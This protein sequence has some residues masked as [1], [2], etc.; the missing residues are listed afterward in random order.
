MKLE[1]QKHIE[2]PPSVVWSITEDVERWPE[3]T[4]TVSRITRLDTGPFDVGSTARIKQPG[5]PETEWR[6]TALTKGEGFTWETRNFGIR[7]IATHELLPSGTDTTSLLR[8][9]M[10]GITLRILSLLI[11]PAVRKALEQENTGLKAACEAAV[12][13]RE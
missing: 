3:W 8:I 1:N 13:S 6:V 9:E 11:R 10:S 4:P 12:L 2:A 7:T 5:F